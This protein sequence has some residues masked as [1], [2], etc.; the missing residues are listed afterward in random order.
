[1]LARLSAYALALSTAALPVLAEEVNV[2]SHRQPELIQPLI[3]AG[4]P[5][6]RPRA[7]SQVGQ[8]P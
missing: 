5:G 2:Y 6:L 3:E 4:F 8:G 1:M 7:R